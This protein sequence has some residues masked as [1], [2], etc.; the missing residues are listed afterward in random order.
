MWYRKVRKKAWLRFVRIL[1]VVGAVVTL[2]VW[3][4][5]GQRDY[6]EEQ[7]TLWIEIPSSF[8]LGPVDALCGARRAGKVIEVRCIVV[9]GEALYCRVKCRR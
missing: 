1:L 5:A 7:Q 6:L 3:S 9:D 8:H 4:L 2:V